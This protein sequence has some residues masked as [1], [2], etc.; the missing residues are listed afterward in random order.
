MA[1]KD[2]VALPSGVLGD[3]ISGYPKLSGRMGL[4][5]EMAMFRRFGTLNAQMLL[6]MQSELIH[7][8]NELRELET[9]DSRSN[10][11]YKSK[12]SRDA[13]FLYNPITP[14]DDRQLRLVM[15]IK[16]KLKEYNKAL[17]LQSSLTSMPEPSKYDLEYIQ[18]Y[19]ETRDMGPLIMTGPDADIWGSV[20][21]PKLH[22]PDL[23]AL[24]ARHNEDPFSKWITNT[25]M[26]IFFWCGF[27]RWRKASPVHGLIVYPDSKLLRITYWMTSL[28]ASLLPVSSII[29]LYYITSTPGRLVIIAGFNIVIALCLLGLTNARR[30]EVFAVTAA[31]AAVQVV[32]IGTNG[33]NETSKNMG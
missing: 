17:K 1:K 6:Y 28:L 26:K 25:G 10:Q 22:V 14:G 13:F 2:H 30:S 7:L 27:H 19:M 29:I 11:P 9:E 32:F 12:Y 31:F 23:V 18:R 4:V 33:T 3:L 15:E 16:A 5:P 8:E 21:E 24:R 20:A